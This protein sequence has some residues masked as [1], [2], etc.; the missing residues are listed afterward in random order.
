MENMN[1][2]SN[3]ITKDCNEFTY[4]LNIINIY[5]YIYIYKADH[6]RFKSANLECTDNKKDLSNITKFE[7]KILALSRRVD[8]YRNN[9]ILIKKLIDLLNIKYYK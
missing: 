3:K 4:F 5:I 9:K 1:W 2:L 6:C 8:Y 7:L